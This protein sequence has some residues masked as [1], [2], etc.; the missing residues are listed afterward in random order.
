[1]QPRW[2]DDGRSIFYVNDATLFVADFPEGPESAVGNARM[3]FRHTDLESIDFPRY[4]VSANGKSF[5]YI[6]TLS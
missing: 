5:V 2:A 1:M 6:E 3:L 4:D